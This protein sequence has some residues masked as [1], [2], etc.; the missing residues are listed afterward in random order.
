M[1]HMNHVHTFITHLFT[2]PYNHLIL[3]YAGT[4]LIFILN[5]INTC[6]DSTMHYCIKQNPVYG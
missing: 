4:Y 6:V 5:P 2:I 1:Y 3:L